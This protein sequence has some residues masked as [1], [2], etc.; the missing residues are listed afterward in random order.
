MIV[1]SSVD[2]DQIPILAIRIV[3]VESIARFQTAIRRA[4]NTWDTAPAEIKEFGD[5]LEFG[6]LLQDYQAQAGNKE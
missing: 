4:L 6:H 5:L 3:G 1:R 2:A